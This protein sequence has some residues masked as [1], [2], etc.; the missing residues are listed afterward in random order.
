MKEDEPE[1]SA[2][3]TSCSRSMVL[4]LTFTKKR[5]KPEVCLRSKPQLMQIAESLTEEAISTETS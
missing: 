3:D 4:A 1:F 2:M 5:R